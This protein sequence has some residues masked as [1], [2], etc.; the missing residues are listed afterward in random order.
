MKSAIIT[1]V[2]LIAATAIFSMAPTPAKAIPNWPP[3]L[4]CPDVNA[5][6]PV[7]ILDIGWIV[8]KFG[9]VYPQDEYLL[10]Y[11]ISGGGN[12]DSIDLGTVA[13]AFG[14]FCPLME[15]Q[16]AAAALA[17]AKYR[18][19]AVATTDGYIQWSQYIP[20]MGIHQVNLDRITSF[21]P[22]LE[23][24]AGLLYAQSGELVG[25][26]YIVPTPEL[27]IDLSIFGLGACQDL[28]PVGFGLT[29]QD[30]D[31]ID[32]NSLQVGW[33]THAGL[34]SWDLGTPQATLADSVSEDD[35]TS[36][37]G[38]WHE[39]YGWMVHLYTQIPNPNGRFLAWNQNVP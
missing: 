2:I 9:T 28:E 18:D 16:I 10:V 36:T 38:F 13:A 15:T 39:R 7:N 34:C 25:I 30:E 32:A 11:D 31:N 33:H 8:Q 21:D 20:N 27:C 29:D 6:G 35:C 24:P 22:Q 26:Y 12:V 17:V 14:T 1:L 4:N 3:L 23:N 5:D 19:P 37:G